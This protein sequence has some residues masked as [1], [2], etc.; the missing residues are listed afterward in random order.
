MIVV[1]L[2]LLDQIL[3]ADEIVQFIALLTNMVQQFYF[4][5]GGTLT[6][7][8]CEFASSYDRSLS[9]WKITVGIGCLRHVAASLSL[10]LFLSISLTNSRSA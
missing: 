7:V 8:T 1:A 2:I 4:S 9:L 10:S 5:V 6:F 3:L